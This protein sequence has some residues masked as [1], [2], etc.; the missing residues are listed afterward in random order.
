M[1]G[2]YEK[3][4]LYSLPVN[5]IKALKHQDKIKAP[6]LIFIKSNVDV[7]VELIEMLDKIVAALKLNVDKTEYIVFSGKVLMMDLIANYQAEKVLVFGAECDDLNL[8]MHLS[9]YKVYNI[10]QIQLLMVNNIIDV[11]GNQKLKA[12]LWQQ[13]KSM[14]E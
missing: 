11:Y 6:F 13:L 4:T 14:F 12:T 7:N 2:I 8:N 5:K 1:L 10:N 3:S 9:L